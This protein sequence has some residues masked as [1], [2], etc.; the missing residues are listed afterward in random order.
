M[1]ESG[2]PFLRLLVLATEDEKWDKVMRPAI[3]EYATALVAVI[4]A[5]KKCGLSEKDMTRLII[6]A[7]E[8]C[9]DK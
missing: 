4:E 3:R 8:G 6:Y 1:I 7:L 2:L 9:S 5:G